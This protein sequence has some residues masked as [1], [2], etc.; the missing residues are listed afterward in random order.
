MCVIIDDYSRY[1]WVIFIR[2][3]S[4]TLYEFSKLCKELQNLMSMPVASIKSDHGR[5]FDQLDFDS[6][7]AKYVISHNLSAPR[8]PRQN[9]V[10]ER[11]NRTLE[12]MSR[13]ML[14][15]HCMPK[16]FWA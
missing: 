12:D 10:V 14:L 5:E 6:F 13:A 1:T 3:K 8:T 15:E 16:F 7:C 2:D 4:D 9:G 11:K